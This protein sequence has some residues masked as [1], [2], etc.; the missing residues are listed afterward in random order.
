MTPAQHVQAGT[1]AALANRFAAASQH[2]A[3][4]SAAFL[5]LGCIEHALTYADMA[6][7]AEQRAETDFV[8]MCRQGAPRASAVVVQFPVGARS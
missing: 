1:A 5:R 7:A 6:S 8:A 3:I 4:A 2:Y